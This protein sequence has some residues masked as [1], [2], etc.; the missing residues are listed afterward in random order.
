VSHATSAAFHGTR[1]LQDWLDEAADSRRSGLQAP[2]WQGA[3]GAAYK[4]VV[5]RAD[6]KEVMIAKARLI[7]VSSATCAQRTC[8]DAHSFHKKHGYRGT[9]ACP[10]PISV[11]Q[12]YCGVAESANRA[13]ALQCMREPLG[14]HRRAQPRCRSRESGFRSSRSRTGA[15]SAR[16]ST[17][18]P[19]SPPSCLT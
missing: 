10:L 2:S 8:T 19:C 3:H 5:D 12:A 6:Q 13:V 11:S 18:A 9:L 17:R 1:G 4:A 16:S 14:M 15:R 7:D